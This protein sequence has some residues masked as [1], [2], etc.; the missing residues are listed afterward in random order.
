M[1]SP[2][3]KGHFISTVA[4]K[5]VHFMGLNRVLKSA[6][7]LRSGFYGATKSQVVFNLRRQIA[8][9]SSLKCPSES[10]TVI[11]YKHLH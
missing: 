8:I 11:I 5:H 1:L 2:L 3:Q 6:S 7:I 4:Q 10:K 9:A